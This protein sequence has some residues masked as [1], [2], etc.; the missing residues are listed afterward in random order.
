[1]VDYNPNEGE[2]GMPAD[3]HQVMS[4][5]SADPA[6]AARP[7][8]AGGAVWRQQLSPRPNAVVY[9]GLP[10][11]GGGEPAYR[12][13]RGAAVAAGLTAAGMGPRPTPFA[14]SPFWQGARGRLLC[15]P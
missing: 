2:V 11:G 13:G 4:I 7:Y 6:G 12:A 1:F 5:G 9:D 3:A 14:A 8:S 15:V 10:L